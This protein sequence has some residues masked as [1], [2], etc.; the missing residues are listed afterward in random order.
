V[1]LCARAIGKIIGRLKS[2]TRIKPI[3]SI[4]SVYT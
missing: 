3:R 2:D 1:A 4:T